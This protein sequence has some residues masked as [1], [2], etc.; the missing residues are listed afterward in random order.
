[1]AHEIGFLV[2][3]TIIT[4]SPDEA[5]EF[6]ETCGRE[7]VFKAIYLEIMDYGKLR[8]GIPTTLVTEKHVNRLSLVR[9]LPALFQEL[10][11]KAFELRVT[12]VGEHIFA[13]R[14]RP[15]SLNFTA[16]D[17]RSPDVLIQ[18]KHD[19]VTL[20][21]ATVDRCRALMKILGL[22]FAAIDFVGAPDGRLFFLEINP[23]GQ[24]YWLEQLTG[25]KISDAIADVLSEASNTR[26]EKGGD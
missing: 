24:W 2:P 15:S 9:G 14:S 12:I 19:L 16:I 20:D 26:N 6:Y 23:N 18:L 21:R 5:K 25:A 3:Q 4:N 7:M 1:M 22:S 17:W 13:V 10:L 11:P 8:L